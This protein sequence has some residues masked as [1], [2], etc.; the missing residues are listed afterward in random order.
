MHNFIHIPLV[1]G[2]FVLPV[3]S[4]T[5]AEAEMSTE[6]CNEQTAQ[7]CSNIGII[8]RTCF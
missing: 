1:A 3:P 8:V 2:P 5:Q 6:Y 4:T 7:T